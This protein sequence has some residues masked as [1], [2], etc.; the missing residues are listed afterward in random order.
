MRKALRQPHETERAK[1][2]YSEENE[3][4]KARTGNETCRKAGEENVRRQKVND[5]DTVTDKVRKKAKLKT[6]LGR[7]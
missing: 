3:H 7:E 5:P 1:E 6:E 4:L 2:N